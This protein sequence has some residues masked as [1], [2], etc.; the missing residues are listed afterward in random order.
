MR[1]SALPTE[2]DNRILSFCGHDALHN[3]SLVFKYY[4]KLSKPLLY[5][6]IKFDRKLEIHI[7]LLLLTLVHRPDCAEHI[8]SVSF[9]AEW[10]EAVVIHQYSLRHDPGQRLENAVGVIQSSIQKIFGRHPSDADLRLQWL[11]AIIA[12]DGFLECSL[13]LI[14]CLAVNLESVKYEYPGPLL[15]GS[16]L[17]QFLADSQKSANR[18]M[19]PPLA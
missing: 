11:R 15:G 3:M 18:E 5:R 2:L 9:S 12:D 7:R 16:R 19:G 17:G 6:D 13:A 1:F 4:R 10:E 14:M 8:K